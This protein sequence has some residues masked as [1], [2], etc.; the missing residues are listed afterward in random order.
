MVSGAAALAFVDITG[1]VKAESYAIVTAK[2]DSF[3]LLTQLILNAKT[4]ASGTAAALRAVSEEQL[5]SLTWTDGSVSS[6]RR[7]HYRK[8]AECKSPL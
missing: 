3:D 5:R 4:K 2:N 7:N 1:T 6:T 8:E